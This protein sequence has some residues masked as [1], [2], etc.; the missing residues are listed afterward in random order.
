MT[1]HASTVVWA[2]AC[3]AA[4]L[5]GLIVIVV[6]LRP[7]AKDRRSSVNQVDRHHNPHAVDVLRRRRYIHGQI[8]NHREE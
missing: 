6:I 7:S 8:E 2:T 3:T 1:I 5:I 4:T